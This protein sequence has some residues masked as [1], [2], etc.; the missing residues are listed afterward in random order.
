MLTR[1]LTPHLRA[2]T[3]SAPNL[4]RSFTAVQSLQRS[5]ALGD[6]GPD[7]GPIFDAKQRAFREKLAAEAEAKKRKEAE[8][9][10]YNP[11][12]NSLLSPAY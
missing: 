12:L 8:E 4:S 9:S 6:I 3:S 1:S 11:V 5:P 7:N 2:L 10:A